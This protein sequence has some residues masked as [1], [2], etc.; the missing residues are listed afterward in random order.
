MLLNGSSAHSLQVC[1][2]IARAPSSAPLRIHASDC[3][4]MLSIGTPAPHPATEYIALLSGVL[5]MMVP[6]TLYDAA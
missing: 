1:S 6:H 4:S 3:P 2:S 5:C